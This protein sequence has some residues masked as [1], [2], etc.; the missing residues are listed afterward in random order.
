MKTVKE[1]LETLNSIADKRITLRDVVDAKA[2]YNEQVEETTRLI[3][4]VSVYGSYELQEKAYNYVTT[5]L[6][7]CGSFLQNLYNKTIGE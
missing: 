5:K 1:L 4:K 3:Q 7:E 2:I 6:K